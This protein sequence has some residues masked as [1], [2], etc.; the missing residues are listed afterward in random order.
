MKFINFKFSER[1]HLQSKITAVCTRRF[2]PTVNIYSKDELI[3][4]LSADSYFHFAYYSAVR[5]D[6]EDIKNRKIQC[7][8]LTRCAFFSS[9]CNVND[10]HKQE[11][12]KNFHQNEK[13]VI[14]DILYN[15]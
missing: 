4:Q 2:T 10:V 3:F 13:K 11:A 6:A 8:L 7:S 5:E 9:I 12:I 14:F 15:N 1:H